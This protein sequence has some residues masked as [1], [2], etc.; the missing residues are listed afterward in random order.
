MSLID[1]ALDSLD[2][3]GIPLV[4]HADAKAVLGWGGNNVGVSQ[5]SGRYDAAVFSEKV[6]GQ[7]RDSP[8]FGR[9]SERLFCLL[10]GCLHRGFFQLPLGWR[11]VGL[12]NANGWR[13]GGL[14]RG[15]RLAR[16]RR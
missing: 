7:R 10:G 12:G 8:V 16:R 1:G 13:R 6:A 4:S 14:W 3:R 2:A 15:V 11:G 5:Q 9:V